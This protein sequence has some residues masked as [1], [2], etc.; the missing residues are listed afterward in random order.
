LDFSG[1][2][3]NSRRLIFQATLANNPTSLDWFD[4]YWPSGYNYK[5]YN[6][7]TSDDESVNFVGNFTYIR[8]KIDRSYDPTLTINNSGIASTIR[9]TAGARSWIDPSLLGANSSLLVQEVN[10]PVLNVTVPN[11]NTL[12]F[13]YNGG[14]ALT[15]LGNGVVRVTIESTFKTWKVAGQLDLVAEA[16]DTV[17]FVAGH[18]IVITTDPSSTP[19]SITFAVEES[20]F[21]YTG[22]EGFT[23]ATGFTGSRGAGFTGS[24]GAQGP[25]GFSGSIGF[26]GSEGSGYVGS[27]GISGELGYTGSGTGFTG[28]IGAQGPRGF[29]GST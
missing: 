6:T 25:Q 18:G 15:D 17:E 22:S 19:K 1:E 14:F 4:L 5:E 2:G 13:D 21:G 9:L 8:V 10:D 23:G 11:V 24:V 29:T 20:I 16:V 28:S 3:S 27:Q 12:Q 7:A 26:T